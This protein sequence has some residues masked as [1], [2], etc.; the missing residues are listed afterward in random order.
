MGNGTTMR[1]L[2][3]VI[4]SALLMASTAWAADSAA[5]EPFVITQP[6]PAIDLTAPNT[7]PVV[8]KQPASVSPEAA[9]TAENRRLWNLQNVDI[10]TVIEQVARETGKSFIIDPSVKGQASIVSNK[11]LSPDELYEVF[12]SILQVLGYA[13][14]P[15]ED[16]VIKIVPD[17]N[18]KSL[19]LPFANKS[20]HPTDAL[21]VAVI[22]VHHV[23]V[24]ALVPVLRNLVSQQGHLAAYA[25]SNVVIIADR[26]ANVDRLTEIIQRVDR[27]EIDGAEVVTL[28]YATPSEVAEALNVIITASRGAGT[29]PGQIVIAPDD[30]SNTLIVSGDAT[31]RLKIRTL[32]A[33][34][35]VPT[36]GS[37]N[38]EVIYLRYQRA[39]DMVPVL[40]N[41]LTSYFGNSVGSSSNPVATAASSRVSS[42]QQNRSSVAASSNTGTG[43]SSSGLSQNNF[44]G[45]QGAERQAIGAVIGPY[46]VQAEPNTNSLIITAP[47]DLMRNLKAVIARLDV[48]RAQVLVE[49]VIAEVDASRSNE[50]G[51][52]WRGSGSVIG[53]QVFES[54]GGAGFLD[55][56]QANVDAGANGD[57]GSGGN[58]SEAADAVQ[59]PGSGLTIGIIRNGS[60]RFLL[61]ALSTD[62]S[63]NIL[64]TPSLVAL[65]NS[66]AIISVGTSVPFQT[67]SYVTPANGSEVLPYNTI[68][69]REVGLQ[70]VIK[71][72]ISQG[73]TIQL[74]IM[75]R[76]DALGPNAA[77]DQ[78]TT[79]N[80]MIT[81]RVIVNSDD[82]LVLGGLIQNNETESIA[83]VPLLGDIP[84]I[85]KAFQSSVTSTEK[86][87]LMIFIRPAIMRDQ[88][89]ALQLTN[90]KYNFIR[91]Q[92]ILSDANTTPDLQES[93]F[94][95]WDNAAGKPE[96]LNLPSP[97]DP[98]DQAD[99][100]DDDD[101]E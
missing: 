13:A 18:A 47:S 59:I 26:A 83:K 58:E 76:V 42:G 48:R 62:S 86:T 15:A 97:F 41:V 90:S 39:E 56:L 50:W 78:P 100:D 89:D 31:Q 88:E 60:I 80:R 23:G 45:F 67:G 63:T 84:F 73:D 85:G 70:L 2:L 14:V 65:D 91:E 22:P 7:P 96:N 35:D 11:E 43:S 29:S 49:A 46:G 40:S 28:E 51:V 98:V 20:G 3:I 61:H 79:T 71:P 17:A 87:N 54:N 69:Y 81:T 16:D 99:R 94:L 34:L 38:T 33:Q 1:R 5:P 64:S 37:G 92:Q 93:R 4:S 32:V 66:E 57:A 95:P 55:T 9:Q 24:A 30:R 44:Q 68:E 77:V 8:L 25:P 21:V 36:N 19:A 75:Q 101:D 74:D 53:G 72:Q 10:R 27:E 82:I 52:E 12:L 6:Q